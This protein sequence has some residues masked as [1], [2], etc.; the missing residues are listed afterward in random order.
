MLLNSKNE[1]IVLLWTFNSDVKAEQAKILIQSH[2][3]FAHINSSYSSRFNYYEALNNITVGS[4]RLYTKKSQAYD[5]YVLLAI[6]DFVPMKDIMTNNY[7]GIEKFQKIMRMIPI[8]GSLGIVG[9]IVGLGVLGLV[10]LLFL[11][12]LL[13]I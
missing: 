9:Q 2:G 1:P 3:Y 7:S 13:P 5:V 11:V 8:L 10:I 6:H 12:K 4:I